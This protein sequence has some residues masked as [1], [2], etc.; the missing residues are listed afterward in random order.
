MHPARQA[1]REIS[2]ATSARSRGG[3]VLIR[4]VENA[5]GRI[6]LI[7]RARGYE[8][9]VG[10]GRDF[11][12]VMA[13]RYGLSLDVIG[14]SLEDIPA[15]GPLVV[16]SNHPYGI[17]DGLAMGLILSGRRRG[18]FRIIANTVFRRATELERVILP[19]SFDGTREALALNMATRAEALGYLHGG[20]A[21]GIFPGGTVSTAARPLS[22]P[23]DPAWRTF[24]A[25]MILK[26]NATVVPVY[27][28]GRN[29][30]LFQVASHVHQTLRLAL[31]VRE[32]RARID[33]PVRLAVGKPVP[34]AEIAARAGDARALMDDLRAATY[35][36]DPRGTGPVGLGHDFG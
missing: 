23:L 30:R 22:R 18:D 21:I 25:K 4:A 11:W 14:G 33:T 36:L 20:G 7:R 28:D 10:Q 9:E 12:A 8:D 5:T 26:S 15:T 31:L 13:R 3:K 29:S 32:F 1:T 2:Y 35:S 17:L 19:I 16:V 24:T 27:F 34:G 6:G